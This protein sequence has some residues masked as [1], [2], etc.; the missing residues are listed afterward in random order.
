MK[1]YD[2]RLDPGQVDALRRAAR[3]R[4]YLQG[5]DFTWVQLLREG[6]E[7]VLRQQPQ[8]TTKT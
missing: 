5:H 1:R 4:S 8:T 7:L 3:E 6:A 2:V